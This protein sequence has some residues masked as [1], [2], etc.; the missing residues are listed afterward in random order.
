MKWRLEKNQS[1]I[2]SLNAKSSDHNDKLLKINEE[3][4]NEQEKTK[5]MRELVK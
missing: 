1:L 2:D 3:L 5:N 4:I